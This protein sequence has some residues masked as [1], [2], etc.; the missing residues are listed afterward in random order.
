MLDC[1]WRPAA[2]GNKCYPVTKRPYPVTLLRSWEQF[3]SR[4]PSGRACGVSGQS[5]VKVQIEHM[6]EFYTKT[7]V[8]K[9]PT[10]VTSLLLLDGIAGLRT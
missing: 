10:F 5:V 4:L 8:L 2:E 9:S 3:G 6:S 7:D 1:F